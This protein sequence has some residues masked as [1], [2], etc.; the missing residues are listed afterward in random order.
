MR[1]VAIVVI[2]SAG[3]LLTVGI[4]SAEHRRHGGYC[5]PPRPVPHHTYRHHHVPRAVPYHYRHHGHHP[6]HGVHRHYVPTCAPYVGGYPSYNFGY[7][8]SNFSLHFGF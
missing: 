6:Y 5:A 3:L 8:G 4:A 1:R 7:H 2:V